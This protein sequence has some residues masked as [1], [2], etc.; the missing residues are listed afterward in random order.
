MCGVLQVGGPFRKWPSGHSQSLRSP[1]HQRPARLG[2]SAP[3]IHD[4][5]AQCGIEGFY[6]LIHFLHSPPKSQNAPAYANI[7]TFDP[8]W[9]L[10][11]IQQSLLYSTNPSIPIVHSS[12][13]LISFVHQRR[14]PDVI[15]LHLRLLLS[16]RS[17]HHNQDPKNPDSPRNDAVSHDYPHSLSSQ[18]TA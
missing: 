13:S 17:P 6:C 14:H 11:S 18:D 3:V 4:D 16:L 12:T 9:S 8:V 1:L 7:R 5:H 15:P 2:R 10:Y